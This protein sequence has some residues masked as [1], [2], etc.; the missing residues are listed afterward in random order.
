MH[1]CGYLRSV[2]HRFRRLR[3]I[4]SRKTSKRSIASDVQSLLQEELSIQPSQLQGFIDA[5]Y[6]LD[7]VRVDDIAQVVDTLL[8]LSSRERVKHLVIIHPSLLECVELP[9]RINLH[10]SLFA[11]LHC[12]HACMH[13]DIVHGGSNLSPAR[14]AL[15]CMIMIPP[16]TH[17]DSYV[18]WL[19]FLTS[20]GMRPSDFFKLLSSNTPI[21]TQV[22]LFEAGQVIMYLTHTLGITHRDLSSSI[23]PKCAKVGV[24]SDSG[25]RAPS[26]VVHVIIETKV[27]LHMHAYILVTLPLARFLA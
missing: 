3:P 26:A 13:D 16:D 22:S 9:G 18:G 1:S 24:S 8:T 25:G 5:G 6:S 19:S 15:A 12:V 17:L 4:P 23:L 14:R 7:G 21:F 27:W 10:S 2:A 11:V 20:Y